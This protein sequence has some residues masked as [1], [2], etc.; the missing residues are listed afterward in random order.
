MPRR[1]SV[2]TDL[3]DWWQAVLDETKEFV[4]DRIDEVRGRHDPRWNDEVAALREAVAELT[5][6]VDGMAGVPR[7]RPPKPPSR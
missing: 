3:L 5:S 7:E 2:R 4:D 1:S 6:K